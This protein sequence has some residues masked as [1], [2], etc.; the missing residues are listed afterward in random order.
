MNFSKISTDLNISNGG[1]L[2]EALSKAKRRK[3]DLSIKE[4]QKEREKL[5]DRLTVVST[6]IESRFGNKAFSELMKFLEWNRSLPNN[7]C[8]ANNLMTP[9]DLDTWQNHILPLL[10]K[11]LH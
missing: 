3:V 5:I 9:K 10:E 8:L 2:Q 7:L 1:I 11:A 6:G 4:V